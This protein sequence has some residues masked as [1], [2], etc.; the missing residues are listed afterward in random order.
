MRRIYYAAAL[1]LT[2]HPIVANTLL[3]GL[4]LVLFG[5]L[6]HV[7]KII[8]SFETLPLSHLPNYIFNA[9]SHGEIFTLLSMAA[10][11]LASARIL[12]YLSQFEWQRPVYQA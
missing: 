9:L 6:V 10:M 7:A 8:E 12:N 5:R 11:A 4:A 2:T 3:F 1:R